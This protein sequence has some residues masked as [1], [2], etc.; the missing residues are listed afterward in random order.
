MPKGC[1]CDLFA[2]P[3]WVGAQALGRLMWEGGLCTRLVGERDGLLL[4]DFWENGRCK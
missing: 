2:Q 1:A 4:L 3:A